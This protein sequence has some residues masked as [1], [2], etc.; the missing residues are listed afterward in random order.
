M[1]FQLAIKIFRRKLYSLTIDCFENSL[2][3]RPS[4]WLLLKE[5]M[6]ATAP[7]LLRSMAE[8]DSFVVLCFLRNTPQAAFVVERT[9]GA[10]TDSHSYA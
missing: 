3:F 4:Q 1:Y 5:Q 7:R 9:D 10:D 2:Y 8:T 6:T